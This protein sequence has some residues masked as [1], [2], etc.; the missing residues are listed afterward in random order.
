[1]S[2]MLWPLP[3]C[4]HGLRRSDTSYRVF[5]CSPR[6]PAWPATTGGEVPSHSTVPKEDNADAFGR[7]RRRVDVASSLPSIARLMARYPPS[8]HLSALAC[9]PGQAAV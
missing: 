4:A 1:L 5:M 6:V 3:A 8:L 7:R 9:G 2:S